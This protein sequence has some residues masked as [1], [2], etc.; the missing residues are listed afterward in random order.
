MN[1]GIETADGGNKCENG[2]D[3]AASVC[4]RLYRVTSFTTLQLLEQTGELRFSSGR[5]QDLDT[6]T[7]FPTCQ[8]GHFITRYLVESTNI[9]QRVSENLIKC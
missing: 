2:D 6:D 3:H 7:P 5:R 9:S 1:I 8:T 4:I